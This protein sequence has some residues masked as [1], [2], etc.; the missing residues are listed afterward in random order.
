MPRLRL[1][2]L[3]VDGTLKQAESPYQYLHQRLGVAHLAASNRELALAGRISFGEWL[4]RDVALWAGQPV[5]R[6]Q[7]LLAE[8]PYLPGAPEL[9]RAL[10]QAGVIVALVSAGFTLNTDPI[11]AEFGLDYVLANEL[12][13][14]DGVLDGRAINRVDEGSKARFACQ[15]MAQL[16]ISPEQTLAAGDTYTDLELFECAGVRWAVNP[17]SAELRARADAVFEP[18]LMGAVDWLAS[19]GYI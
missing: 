18:D 7:Q 12:L 13:S 8:N 3:D 17:R 2:V 1:A 11:M 19:R 6:I 15:L 9:L 4:R 16:G 14:V 10:K 5:A